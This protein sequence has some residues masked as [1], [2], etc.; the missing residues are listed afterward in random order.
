MNNDI[1]SDFPKYINSQSSNQKASVEK[2]VP[3]QPVV[4]SQDLRPIADSMEVL[5]AM[6]HAQVNMENLYVNHGIKHSVE[7]YVQDPLYAQSW[8]EYCDSLVEKGYNLEDALD[9]TDKF[10]SV[11]KDKNIYS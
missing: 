1:R 9:G 4:E 6:G 11:L 7:Q 8:V 5:S 10:F 2:S 3:V